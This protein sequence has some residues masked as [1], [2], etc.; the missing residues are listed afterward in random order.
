MKR[1]KT[2]ILAMA[3]AMTM[4]C[5]PAMSA[6]AAVNITVDGNAKS[7]EA[8]QLLDLT[9]SLKSGDTHAE[10]EHTK[11]CYN[12]S[13]KVNAKYGAIV[14]E[15]APEADADGNGTVTDDEL[16]TY[17]EG[18]GTEDTRAFADNV[19]SQIVA[20]SIAADYTSTGK[21]LTVDEQGYYLIVEAESESDPD[22]VSLVMLDTAGADDI[23]VTSKEDIPELTKKVKAAD[24]NYVDAVDAARGD[25]V[26]FQ[27]TGD[28]PNNVN[29]YKTYKYVFHDK[30]GA[31]L[32]FDK[33]ASVTIG[34]TAVDAA[35]YTVTNTGLTDDCSVEVGIADMIALAKEMGITL[36]TDTKVVVNY[37]ATVNEN[38]VVGN[39]GNSND[40]HLEFSNNPY[41]ADATSNTPVD[42]VKVFQFSVVINKIDKDG[43]PLTGAEF[44]LYKMGETDWEAINTMTKNA[45]GTEFT[46]AGL[47]HGS[48]KLVESTVPSGYNKADDV[49]F[50]IEAVYDT[51]SA[52]PQVTSLVIKQSDKVVSSGEG[53]TFQ[54]SAN[55]G[56]ATGSVTNTTGIQLPHTGEFGRAILLY[57][58]TGAIVVAFAAVVVAGKKKNKEQA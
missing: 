10:N 31:G 4:L 22:S 32:T 35:K 7:Y 53:A 48:Y 27:L 55:L 44:T 47:E 6:Q 3:L 8:Y 37:T 18:M 33:V 29:N 23:K 49:L 34:G 21:I 52:D 26:E 5:M 57:G 39:A 46:F 51:D 45:A 17:L 58:G 41:V 30:M 1:K 56:T 42:T 11:D 50:D 2:P 13:Y 16:I 19:W 54:I 9:T 12:Y 40:A 36:N 15:A 28:L 24:G 14:K 20:G 43:D 38:A 25:T